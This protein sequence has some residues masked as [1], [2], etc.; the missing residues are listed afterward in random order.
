MKIQTAKKPS[1]FLTNTFS[2]FRSHNFRLYFAGRL[3]SQ[4][5]TWMQRTSVSWLIFTMTHSSLMLGVSAFASQFP[6]FFFSLFGGVL[7]DRYSKKRILLITQT[8]SMVQAVLLVF[9]VLNK[10]YNV[11][12][13]LILSSLLG[14]I[15]AFDS[16]ARQSMINDII[17]S[18]DDLPNALALSS[19]INDFSRL[20]GP[21]IAGLVLLKFGASFCFLLNAISFAAVLLSIIMIR[22]PAYLPATAKKKMSADLLEGFRYLRKTPDISLSILMLALVSLLVLPYNTLLPIFAKVVYKG[23]A[24]TFGYLNSFIGLGA[25]TGLMFLAS[26]KPGT[27]LKKVLLFNT[28]VMG[29]CMILFSLSN[30]FILAI[31]FATI[32]SFG[33]TSQTTISNT[34]V[35]GQASSEMRGRVVSI[36]LMAYFGMLPLGS[37]LVGVIAQKIGA[38][39]TVF[40]QVSSH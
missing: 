22:W 26:L 19:S 16:P 13:I 35:Q 2:A 6:S 14:I 32:G 11:W 3:V 12:G 34:I 4:I 37:M 38:Q 10:Q 9:L 27:N 29:I 24:A 23:D 31:L 33:M 39:H 40:Y 17:D 5:G 25:I 36:F 18:K 8:A 1:A 28:V 20:I 15:N 7:S 30:S 21:A